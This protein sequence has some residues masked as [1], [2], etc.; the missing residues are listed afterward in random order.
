MWGSAGKIVLDAV[1]KRSSLRL[2]AHTNSSLNMPSS[3]GT[4][5]KYHTMNSSLANPAQSQFEPHPE[6]W[7]SDKPL[8][9]VFAVQTV[10]GR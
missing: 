8:V 4:F 3:A 6:F 7:D 5:I 10:F 9:V 2:F 1:Q